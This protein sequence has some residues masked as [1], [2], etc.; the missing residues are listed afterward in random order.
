MVKLRDGASE[1]KQREPR[2][3]IWKIASIWVQDVDEA[4][5]KETEKKVAKVVLILLQTA[6]VGTELA[7]TTF[8]YSY[9][10]TN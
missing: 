6:S 3:D 5:E 8:V 7:N 10:V 9:R 2:M 4:M 1:Q